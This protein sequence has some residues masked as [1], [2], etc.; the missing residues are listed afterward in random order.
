M[1]S[2][3]VMVHV[4]RKNFH[5][6]GMIPNH[7]VKVPNDVHIYSKSKMIGNGQQLSPIISER[8]K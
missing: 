2:I 4:D 6:L 7:I 1:K 8:Q 3:V 5:L